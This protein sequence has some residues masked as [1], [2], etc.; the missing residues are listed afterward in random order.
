M[1]LHHLLL[2]FLFFCVL[3][4]SSFAQDIEKGPW[5]GEKFLFILVTSDNQLMCTH[6]SSMLTC[7]E[8]GLDLQDEKHVKQNYRD[9]VEKYGTAKGHVGIIYLKKGVKPLSLKEVL[10]EKGI[11]MNKNQKVIINGDSVSYEPLQPLF[12]P[13]NISKVKK[14]GNIIEI[15]TKDASK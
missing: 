9:C 14:N 11:V 12:S 2:S 5:Y 4:T 10:A 1:N 3:P 15:T 13:S 7:D 8:S 6:Y